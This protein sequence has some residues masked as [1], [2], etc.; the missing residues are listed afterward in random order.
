MLETRFSKCLQPL[1][2]AH[3]GILDFLFLRC[4]IA[5]HLPIRQ[6]AFLVLQIIWLEKATALGFGW[7]LCHLAGQCFTPALTGNQRLGSNSVPVSSPSY[8]LRPW[9]H[10]WSPSQ[11]PL[12]GLSGENA[13]D[14]PWQRETKAFAVGRSEGEVTETKFTLSECDRRVD[15][16]TIAALGKK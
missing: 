14:N 4:K 2:W 10:R 3:R 9:L 5:I 16:V 13:R 1:C 8:D 6:E 12:V 11:L 15:A 7:R